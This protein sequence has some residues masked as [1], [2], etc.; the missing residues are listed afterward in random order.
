MEGIIEGR[1]KII[2]KVLNQSY[3]LKRRNLLKKIIIKKLE[4]DIHEIKTYDNNIL[5]Y[6][7]IST[8]ITKQIFSTTITSYHLI[9]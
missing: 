3:T 7:F 8:F 5:C 6:E 4:E 9:E 1:R 2:N